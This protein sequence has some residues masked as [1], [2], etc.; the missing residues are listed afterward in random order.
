MTEEYHK[1]IRPT[2]KPRF[3]F[4]RQPNSRKKSRNNSTNMT[5]VAIAGATSGIGSVIVNA[6]ALTKQ[7]DVFVLSR[8]V[9][10]LQRGFLL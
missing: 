4:T 3:S 5:R 2:F 1:Q 7:H 8:Q 10:Y 6:I 9:R